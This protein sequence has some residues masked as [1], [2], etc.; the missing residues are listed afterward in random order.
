VAADRLPAGANPRRWKEGRMTPTLSAIGVRAVALTALRPPALRRPIMRLVG[1]GPDE[2]PWQRAA[3]RKAPAI[4][5]VV[6]EIEAERW[7]G[8]G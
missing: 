1:C 4:P 6:D 7:D 8:L 5:D 3:Q 2:A